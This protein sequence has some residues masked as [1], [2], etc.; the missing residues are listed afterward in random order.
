M[1]LLAFLLLVPLAAMAAE[2]AGVK[3]DD[4]T[5]IG[6]T[7]LVLNGAGLRKRAFFQVYAMGVYVQQRS[8]NAATVVEQPGP[9]RVA[10]HMLRNVG[11]DAFNEALAD[12]IRA[13]SSEA[14]AKALEPRLKEL[15]AII[16]G[17]G[18]AKK[19]MAI[20]LDWTG[21][22][23]QVV[24]QGKPVGKP[25]AGEDF[26]RALLRIWVGDRPVQDDLKKALLGGQ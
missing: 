21:A 11:A 6:S 10:I 9:K 14:E 26:Y 15:G 20:H 3:I 16:G 4:K 22:E 24:I 25:I 1:R 12:G 8:G 7:E 2:V 18:E 5:R 23:T 13:N 17:V 19:G